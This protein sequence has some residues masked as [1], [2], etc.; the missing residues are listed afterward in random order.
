MSAFWLARALYRVG[1]F[2]YRQWP[3]SRAFRLFF[4][5]ADR[6]SHTQGFRDYSRI[7]MALAG[8]WAP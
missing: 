2:V 7:R 5:P 3:E 4:A 6:L 8:G 1:A